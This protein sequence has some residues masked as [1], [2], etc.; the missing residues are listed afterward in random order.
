MNLSIELFRSKMIGLRCKLAFCV[1][2]AIGI[3][4]ECSHAQQNQATPAPIRN[5]LK[6]KPLKLPELDQDGK[7]KTTNQVQVFQGRQG[8]ANGLAAGEVTPAPLG[9]TFTTDQIHGQS[10]LGPKD[11]YLID[12]SDRNHRV[13]VND[14]WQVF[15]LDTEDTIGHF[16]TL[17]GRRIASPSNRVAIYAPRFGAVR[18]ISDISGDSVTSR[19][20]SA[21]KKVGPTLA[22]TEDTMSTTLQNVQANRHRT[23]S[24]PLAFL[25]RTRGVN[26]ESVSRLAGL[27]SGY[28]AYENLQLIKFGRLSSSEGSRLRMGMQSAQAWTDNLRVLAEQRNVNVIVANDFAAVQDITL[29]ET[30]GANPT[31]RVVKVASKITAQ[32]GET[33]D[34][35]IRFDNVGNQTIG[36]VTIIDNLTTRLEYLPDTAECSMKGRFVT[37]QN[38]GSS[39]TLR[40]EIEEPL[41]IGKGGVIRFKCRVR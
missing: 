25:D 12:G 1:V 13:Y 28:G 11:E 22:R 31:L 16:D 10:S 29:S 32:P 27:A 20:A 8:F 40:W 26:T 3:S 38:E 34:F 24:R 4:F 2:L 6:R 9:K 21:D 19:L 14:K 36:N 23:T 15:G 17:D 37:Q 41:P 39:L 30:K 35:T 18:R 33:V 7:L 5:R